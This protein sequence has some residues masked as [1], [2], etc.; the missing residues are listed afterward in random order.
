V[1][2]LISGSA[3][4]GMVFGR[5]ETVL[6][7][8][9]PSRPSR[10]GFAPDRL[11]HGA[12][13]V[14]EINVA[15]ESDAQEALEAAWRADRALRLFLMLLDPSEPDEDLVDIAEGL[16]QLFDDAG[17]RT[18]VDRIMASQPLEDRADLG[19]AMVASSSCPQTRAVLDRLTARQAS[20]GQVASAFHQVR[21]DAYPEGLRPFDARWDLISSGAFLDLAD[22]LS[23][24]ENLSFVRLK[25]ASRHP[26]LKEVL[27]RWTALLQPGLKPVSKSKAVQISDAEDWLDYDD[28]PGAAGYQVL[29]EVRE[30]QREIRLALRSL[31]IDRARAL[32]Q[33]LIDHQ[34][35]VSN[36]DQIAK[37]LCFLAQQ[38]KAEEV[39]ALQLEWAEWA[40]RENPVDPRT[41]AHLADAYLKYRR[42]D[43]A[44]AAFDRMDEVGEP[45][46]PAVGRARI[47]RSLGR[48]VEARAA[49]LTAAVEFADMDGVSYASV[50]AAECLRDLGKTEE[51]VAEYR[52]IVARW[53]LEE[54]FLNGL[55]S[56]LMDAGRFDEAI[57]TFG[58]AA[59]IKSGPVTKNG[60]ATAARLSG[61]SNEAL[62]LYDE[63][64]A[65]HPNNSVALT[66]RADALRI[67]GR[68]DDA[69]ASLEEAIRRVPEAPHPWVAKIG[70]LNNLGRRAEALS[71]S[72]EALRQFPTDYHFRVVR[73]RVYLALGRFDE[74]LLEVDIATA[75]SPDEPDA[76]V[77][78][79]EILHHRGE[80][81]EA[82]RILDHIISEKQHISAAV[83]AKAALLIVDN[84][85]E[86]AE[87]LLSVAEPRTQ[88]D[89]SRYILRGEVIAKSN[90]RAAFRHLNAGIRK[91]PFVR[92]KTQLRS[93]L[94]ALELE[95]GRFKEAQRLIEKDASSVSN[96]V[97]L[98]IM[99]SNHRPGRARALLGEIQA[100][101]TS[102][103][104]IYL[105]EEIARRHRVL[106]D[107]PLQSQSWIYAMHRRA[108]VLEAV[109]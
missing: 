94:A 65:S 47:L 31:D 83:T 70:L 105:A 28:E 97:Q 102:A 92:Q 18:F 3:G 93:A 32:T 107:K 4:V 59:T 68:Y 30:R 37:S 108:I 99:A 87:K 67:A 8:D 6:C 98:H 56:V 55:A 50:G 35:P 96:V 61:K 89:W 63:V 27:A 73:S 22:G 82:H 54:S 19:R 15:R 88:W 49:F 100:S 26:L 12:S 33:A 14:Q 40:T 69:F 80:A 71:V 44:S 7:V 23:S 48:F 58:R 79:A 5:A 109:A 62:A 11:F 45:V 78:R 91:C 84:R 46:Y 90:R 16:E 51:A 43:D 13:D 21:F 60:R 39:S 34:R 17:A 53:P 10:G 106:D 74:A 41:F 29:A 95:Q 57:A 72:E 52:K 20:A 77:L 24:G 2:A 38:A 85:L 104:I 76:A 36:P 66:G 9:G 86:E 75:Q 101:E 81:N 1:K 64:L 103:E 42:F 25:L